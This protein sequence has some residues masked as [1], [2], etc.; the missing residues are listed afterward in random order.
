MKR[1][2]KPQ[3]KRL[4]T[5]R[6]QAILAPSA[7]EKSSSFRSKIVS[8]SVPVNAALKPSD[9]KPF[10]LSPRGESTRFPNPPLSN[11]APSRTTFLG[12]SLA[13][14]CDPR[15][16][17]QAHADN[18]CRQRNAER[19]A[20]RGGTCRHGLECPSAPSRCRPVRQRDQFVL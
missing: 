15:G 16:P 18:A 10:L 5:Q 20:K 7:T 1:S 19:A 4:S 11:A 2:W 14:C 9:R 6:G 3:W 12:G 8:V 17:R 13:R